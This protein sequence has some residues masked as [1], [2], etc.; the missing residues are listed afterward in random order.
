MTSWKGS[1]SFEVLVIGGS[2]AG[3][4]I[5]LASRI[6][7]LRPRE[8]GDLDHDATFTAGRIEPQRETRIGLVGMNSDRT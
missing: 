7:K 4:A 8:P 5:G 1:P 6:T 2:Q 3:L